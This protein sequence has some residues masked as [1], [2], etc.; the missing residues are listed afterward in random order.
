[1]VVSI[2]GAGWLGK[3]L[4]STLKD[5]EISVNAS[6]RPYSGLSDLEV[7]GA[8][9]YQI[10]FTKENGLVANDAFFDCDCLVICMSQRKGSDNETLY[11][12]ALKAYLEMAIVNE[13]NK[14]VF[15]SS[16]GIYGKIEGVVDEDLKIAEMDNE[17][18]VLQLLHAEN[19]LLGLKNIDYYILRLAGLIGPGR[20]AGRFLAG[21]KN[22][23]NPSAPVNMVEQSDVVS[24]ID[25]F[26]E[27]DFPI[28][29]Y[30]VCAD[31]HPTRKEFY[32]RQALISGLEE[33]KFLE[34]DD[35]SGRIVSN[36]KVKEVLGFQ[37]RTLE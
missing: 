30:N 27:N 32:S 8:N 25:K 13:V 17:D 19:L 11:L 3:A 23:P 21:K 31:E 28:G 22:I 9:A 37:F 2:L 1:M 15:T 5:K 34:K 18:S 20:Q 10:N 26:I 29:I 4:I 16:A 33:P 6:T 12:E 7:L 14:I 35:S 36:Q 24:I